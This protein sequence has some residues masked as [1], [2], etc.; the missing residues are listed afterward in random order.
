MEAERGGKGCK[1]MAPPHH[2]GEAGAGGQTSTSAL[3]SPCSPKTTRSNREEKV[4]RLG[5]RGGGAGAVATPSPHPARGGFVTR[6]A[7]LPVRM[8]FSQ[9][10]HTEMSPRLVACRGFVRDCQSAGVTV[11][12]L[13]LGTPIYIPVPFSAVCDNMPGFTPERLR[14]WHISLSA[15]C[16]EWRWEW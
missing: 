1:E 9:L 7:R 3:L 5:A 12:V 10:N 13:P 16:R 15:N 4:W 2:L 6:E 11:C 8:L 14:P